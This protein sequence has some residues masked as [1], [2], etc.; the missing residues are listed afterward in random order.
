MK[1]EG[2]EQGHVSNANNFID[3]YLLTDHIYKLNLLIVKLFEI[4]TVGSVKRSCPTGLGKSQLP[5][6]Q[7]L[8]ATLTVLMKRKETSEMWKF[9]GEGLE[10]KLVRRVA[11]TP[12]KLVFH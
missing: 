11:V 9:T 7:Q 2:W 4:T 8:Q 6:L 1:F 5:G 3:T 12:V 10:G